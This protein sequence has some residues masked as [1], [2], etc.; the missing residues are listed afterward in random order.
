MVKRKAEI[1]LDE[2]LYQT[3]VPLETKNIDNIAAEKDKELKPSL[4]TEQS[5]PE[6]KEGPATGGSAEGV[7]AEGESS[8]WLWVLLEQA[9]YERW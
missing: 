9:G 1:S 5:I 4:T 2:W 6:V 3:A 7:Q 8:E